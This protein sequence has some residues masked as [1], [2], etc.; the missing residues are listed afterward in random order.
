MA[1]RFVKGVRETPSKALVGDLAAEVRL[2]STALHT[3]HSCEARQHHAEQAGAHIRIYTSQRTCPSLPAHWLLANLQSGD[4]AAAAFSVRQ[5][6]STF[7]MLV[8]SGA[9]AAVFKVCAPFLYARVCV[10]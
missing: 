1:D 2:L 3:V 7:G 4:S 5:A 10:Y 6:L 8:G 9:A